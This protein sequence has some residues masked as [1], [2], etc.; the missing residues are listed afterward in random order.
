M[1]RSGMKPLTEELLNSLFLGVHNPASLAGLGPGPGGAP[2]LLAG[3]ADQDLD[4]DQLDL[5]SA[6]RP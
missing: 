5:V 6:D 2:T 3:D 1:S 4:F